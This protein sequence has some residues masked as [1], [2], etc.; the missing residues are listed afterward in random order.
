MRTGCGTATIPAHSS[1]PAAPASLAIGA[2]WPMP[3]L[4]VIQ[5]TGMA[6]HM[7][8]RQKEVFVA[9]EREFEE[10]WERHV[11][12]RGL[13]G[14]AHRGLLLCCLAIATHRVL[15]YETGDDE[16]VK[17]VIRTNLGGV[18]D[19]IMLKLHKGRLWLLLRLLAEDPYKQAVRFLP[20]LQGDMASL[21]SSDLVAGP[22]EATWTASA[23]AFHAALAAE[24]ATELLP[25]FCCQYGMQYL[26]GFAQYGVR[27]GLE[28]SLGF[29]DDRCCV[30]ISR[31]GPPPS[32]PSQEPPA[33]AGPGPAE[34][35]AGPQ[36]PP[37]P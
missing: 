3:P 6:P 11:R 18:A 4:N 7:A 9:V 22:H 5:R 36:Q 10:L 33:A 19:N 27:V 21:V 25:H 2:S 13:Q 15:R 1:A 23:C 31:P 28:Q 17:E 12:G 20:Q 32:P 16:L 26:E 34:G 14:V 30:R 8:G 37:A 24:D 29:G 35:Q